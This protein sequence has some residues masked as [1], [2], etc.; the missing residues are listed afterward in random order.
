MKLC[1]E[2][3]SYETLR[4]QK[5]RKT[6]LYVAGMFKANKYHTSKKVTTQLSVVLIKRHLDLPM[7]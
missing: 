7:S 3:Q 2:T 5:N 6:A 4:S 1:Y